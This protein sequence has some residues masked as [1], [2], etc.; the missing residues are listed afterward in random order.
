[1]QL[2]MFRMSWTLIRWFEHLSQRMNEWSKNA[3]GSFDSTH[4]ARCSLMY[5]YWVNRQ[6][7][8]KF[9]LFVIIS[10]LGHSFC[11]NSILDGA[12]LRTLSHCCRI[13]SF[14]AKH[15]LVSLLTKANNVTFTLQKS[16]HVRSPCIM[17]TFHPLNYASFSFL[18]P[19]D[20]L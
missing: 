10:S 5:I 8:S 17:Y 14:L 6:I 9:S 3:A 13:I 20:W 4:W 2:I 1:M 19:A 12:W 11:L 7:S 16:V 15:G 18:P